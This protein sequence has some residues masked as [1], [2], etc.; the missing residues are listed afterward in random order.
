MVFRGRASNR[1]KRRFD[2]PLTACPE[3]RHVS[4]VRDEQ[5]GHRT[6]CPNCAQTFRSERLPVS[7]QRMFRAGHPGGAAVGTLLLLAGLGLGGTIAALGN[8]GP[9]EL[10]LT[11]KIALNLAAVCIIGG[12]LLV[13]RHVRALANRPQAIGARPPLAG[14]SGF[15]PENKRL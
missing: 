1:Q 11:T 14:P 9:G 12:A 6:R 7:F 5:I 3:C 2:M 13:V 8:W 10:T 15:Q 4:A